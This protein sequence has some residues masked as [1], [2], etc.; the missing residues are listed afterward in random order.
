MPQGRG[1]PEEVYDRRVFALAYRS[2]VSTWTRAVPPAPPAA[3][4]R[5]SRE[6]HRVYV[7]TG[8]ARG[9]TGAAGRR[10]GA[11]HRDQHRAGE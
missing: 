10:R 2:L 7:A 8:T 9:R 1:E 5:R 4:G 11:A 3:Q 6:G